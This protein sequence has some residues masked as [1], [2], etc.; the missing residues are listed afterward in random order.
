LS[1][2]Q[3]IRLEKVDQSVLIMKRQLQE[4]IDITIETG[5]LV[6]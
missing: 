3:T 2:T 4:I 5:D 1:G 6:G